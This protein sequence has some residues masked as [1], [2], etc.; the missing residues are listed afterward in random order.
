M[1]SR[2]SSVIGCGNLGAPPKPPHRGSNARRS[3]AI[4]RVVTSAPSGSRD[5]PSC[6]VRGDRLGHPGR[7]HGDLVAP[8]GPRLRHAGQDPPEGRH[9]VRRFLGVVRAGVERTSLRREEGGERPPPVPVHRLHGIHV[10][11]VEVG[12]FLAVDL[13]RDEP[14]V[15][16]RGRLVILERFALHHVTPVARGV[17]DRQEDRHVAV[18]R[19]SEGRFAPRVPVDGVV[20]VLQEVRARLAYEPVRGAIGHAHSLSRLQSGRR[21]CRCCPGGMEDIKVLVVDERPGLT[22]GLLLALPRRGHVRVLGPVPDVSS[23]RE[24]IDAGLVDVIVVGLDRDDG[25]GVA[26]VAAL[27]DADDGARILVATRDESPETV[28]VALAAGA[29]GVLPTERDAHPLIDA[30]RRARAGEL[31]LPARD[32]PLLVDRLRERAVPGRDERA[33][34]ASLTAP[35]IRD[36]RPAL[37]RFVDPRRRRAPRHQSAHGAEPRE[38]H[39]G[40][41][42]GAY[43][44]RGGTDRVAARAA[45][46][47][48][49]RVTVGP[50][51]RSAPSRRGSLRIRW[52]T[53]PSHAS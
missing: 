40:Q 36:P 44:G 16:Q 24:A 47:D 48:A 4:A 37:R 5:S 14:L 1:R 13:D 22:Q 10:D 21:T 53:G 12:P 50:A 28:V 38:E 25:M 8:L 35:R 41:A 32:L 33:L 29:R 18:A 45:H 51:D 49:L 19:R 43:E 9:P 30:F 26:I 2:N 42:R 6:P 3:E 7:L 15:H 20:R 27:R 39:P 11:A 17:P 52:G 46:G 31:V 23:A 34:L